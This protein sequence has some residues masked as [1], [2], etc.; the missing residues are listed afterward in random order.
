MLLV[1]VV[2]VVVIVA[3]KMM[4]NL[5]VMSRVIYPL[6]MGLVCGQHQVPLRR[7]RH[8]R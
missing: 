8:R 1:V 3:I 6:A 2:V 4:G 5:L 7:G